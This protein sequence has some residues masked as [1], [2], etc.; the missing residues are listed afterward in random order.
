MQGIKKMEKEILGLRDITNEAIYLWNS[1][2][3]DQK[4]SKRV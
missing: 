2:R 1:L 4:K 3:F